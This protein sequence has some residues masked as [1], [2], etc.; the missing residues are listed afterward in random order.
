MDEG[1]FGTL[2]NLP[3]S[4]VEASPAQEDRDLV[5]L[6]RNGIV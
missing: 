2:H 1:P 3:A 5:E 4:E 6:A